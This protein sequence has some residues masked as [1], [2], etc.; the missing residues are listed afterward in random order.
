M[1]QQH[2]A[3]MVWEADWTL[4]ATPFYIL[5]SDIFRGQIPAAYGSNDR[6]HLDAVAWR[7]DIVDAWQL[8][9]GH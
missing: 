2:V 3:W 7:Q 4:A 5:L 9:Q 1:H 6:A 8:H